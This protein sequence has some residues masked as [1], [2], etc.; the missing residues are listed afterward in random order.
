MKIAQTLPMAQTLENPSHPVQPEPIPSA[1]GRVSGPFREAPAPARSV[2]RRDPKLTLA[3]I[4]GLIAIIALVAGMIF[5]G[6]TFVDES[7]VETPET[8][9]FE[10]A[11]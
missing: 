1:A 10:A 4:G 6:P 11:R 3:V 8:M 2:S 7:D 9:Q 5:S